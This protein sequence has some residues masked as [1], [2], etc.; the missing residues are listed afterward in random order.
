MHNNRNC[1]SG[2]MIQ[3]KALKGATLPNEQL[4][5]ESKIALQF[6]D[7]WLENFQ[8]SWK[9]NLFVSLNG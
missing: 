3:I 7:G 8:K 1:I 5:G 6:S 9:E 2:A 4:A